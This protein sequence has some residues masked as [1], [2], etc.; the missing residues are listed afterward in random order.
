[1]DPIHPVASPAPEVTIVL[2]TYNRPDTLQAAIRTVLG[3]TYPHWRLL[4]LGDGCGDETRAAVAAFPDPRIRYFNLPMRAGEQSGPNS[5]GLALAAT[6]YLAFLNHDD[7]WLPDHLATGLD[8]LQGTGADFYIGTSAFAFG[9][10]MIGEGTL[11]PSFSEIHGPGR[12]PGHS[13]LPV[14]VAQR[15]AFEPASAWL[16]RTAPAQQVGYWRGRDST[17][18]TTP[19]RDWVARAWRAGL[20][21]VFG[22]RLTVLKV[23]THVARRDAIGKGQYHGRSEEHA[24]LLA[25]LSAMSPETLRREILA[26]VGSGRASRR[27][28]VRRLVVPVRALAAPVVR[29]AYYPTGVDLAGIAFTLA[30]RLLRR[31]R[32]A[33]L[34]SVVRKRTGE[35]FRREVELEEIVRLGVEAYFVGQ[36][37][38][39]SR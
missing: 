9:T 1:M 36:G 35:A 26:E 33:K 25:K 14:T 28:G 19:L 24:A 17:P 16:L 12:R 20:H 7:L 6:P 3:Q 30:E 31:G 10:R 34:Q 21:I 15:R 27:G 37:I 22:E 11:M 18:G 38:R 23:T 4:V 29:A 5:V 32:Q 2:A 13:V 8:T 39:P